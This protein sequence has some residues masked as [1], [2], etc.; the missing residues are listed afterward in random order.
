MW[1]IGQ[2]PSNK[3][4]RTPDRTKSRG[5]QTQQTQPLFRLRNQ[6]QCHPGSFS[7]RQVRLRSQETILAAVYP[8]D[9]SQSRNGKHP[10]R[11]TLLGLPR[12]CA[13][14]FNLIWR[15][16][17]LLFCLNSTDFSQP[18]PSRSTLQWTTIQTGA[19]TANRP[20]PTAAST[21]QPSARP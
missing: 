3:P 11:S 12:S 6:P 2:P 10:P 1:Q 18:Q 9:E 19:S 20:Y 8:G 21:A 17:H 14:P 15:I 4:D 7:I 16:L 5:Y 13:P